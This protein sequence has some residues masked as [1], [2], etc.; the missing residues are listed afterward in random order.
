MPAGCEGPGH[1]IWFND[2]LTGIAFTCNLTGDLVV[3]PVD[4]SSFR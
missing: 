2:E 1:A 3:T 4:M